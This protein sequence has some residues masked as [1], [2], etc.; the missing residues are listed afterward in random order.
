[1]G[2]CAHRVRG[3]VHSWARRLSPRLR[4]ARYPR[5]RTFCTNVRRRFGFRGS[6]VSSA[7]GRGWYRRPR[8]QVGSLCEGGLWEYVRQMNANRQNDTSG[9][10]RSNFASILPG[11]NMGPLL[12]GRPSMAVAWMSGGP[13]MSPIIPNCE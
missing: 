2:L 9:R 11:I 3:T 1:M 7:R 10:L 8:E 4:E 13:S 6:M 12:H 5:F